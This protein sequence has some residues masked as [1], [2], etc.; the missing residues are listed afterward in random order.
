MQTFVSGDD[1]AQWIF[2]VV[3]R[4]N[5]EISTEEAYKLAGEAM[6]KCEVIF[7]D[8]ICKAIEIGRKRPR[9]G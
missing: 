8:M 9:S 7:S 4:E 2:N 5:G 6:A 3:E 1:L